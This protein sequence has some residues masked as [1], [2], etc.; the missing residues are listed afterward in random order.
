MNNIIEKANAYFDSKKEEMLDLLIKLVNM[1]SVAEPSLNPDYPMGKDVLKVLNFMLDK[2]ENEG[3]VTKDYDHYVGG[4]GLRNLNFKET[5]SLVGH[6][7]VVPAIGEWK[8]EA[9]NATIDHGCVIG[10]GASDDKSAAV[11][12]FYILK[13]LKE[14][15]IQTKHNIALLLGTCEE[16]GMDDVQHLVKH[17]GAPK[18]SLIPDGGFPCG[19]G[20]FGRMQILLTSKGKLSSTILDIN[21][22]TAFNI[23]PDYAYAKVSKDL[24]INKIEG[25]YDVVEKEDHI[26]IEAH[27]ISKHAGGG[28]EGAI[29]ANT[30]LV[31]FLLEQDIPQSDKEILKFILHVNQDGRGTGLE[32][33]YEDE[34]SGYT[35]CS[36]T[37]L[38]YKEGNVS[39]LCDCRFAVTQNNEEM[40]KSIHRVSDRF[41]Y[42]DSIESNEAPYYLPMENEGV[43]SLLRVFNK[44][45]GSNVTFIPIMKGGTYASY[46]PNALSTGNCYMS[47]EDWMK[48][49][50]SFLPQGHG[51]AH[52]KDEILPIE[53]FMK[54]IKLLFA[55]VLEM[56]K[57]I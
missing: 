15:N 33:N 3:F 11:I 48:F 19:R 47:R 30:K 36:G 7:D 24:K 5:I 28:G 10:R 38:R 57:S 16:I 45:T 14:L 8:Y 44:L 56:D 54:A 1:K 53:G 42:I 46:I 31:E 35:V 25:K 55:I 27:G 9:Y 12:G 13:C 29:N 17:Y 6:L 26:L 32:I 41:N 22:G 49:D 4:I 39:L 51:G 18:F 23:I 50:F 34:V 2:G 52:Q 20:E 21:G 43:Q 37:V 40:L